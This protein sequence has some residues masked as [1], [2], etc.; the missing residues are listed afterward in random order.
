MIVFLLV[1][2]VGYALDICVH[3]CMPILVCNS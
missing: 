2:C 3:L 1:F